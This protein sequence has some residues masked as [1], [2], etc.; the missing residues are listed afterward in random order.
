VRSALSVVGAMAAAGLALNA[1]AADER[2]EKSIL[3]VNETTQTIQNLYAYNSYS[4]PWLEDALGDSVIEAGRSVT[5]HLGN[6]DSCRYSFQAVLRDGTELNYQR[7]D[8]CAR[9]EL[10]ISAATADSSA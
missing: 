9:H 8:V 6:E 3:I 1:S 7:Y 10:H 2:G 5:L 4:P